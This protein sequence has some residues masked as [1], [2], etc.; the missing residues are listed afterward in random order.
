MSWNKLSEE[1]RKVVRARATRR[2]MSYDAPSAD[3]DLVVEGRGI[4]LTAANRQ[5]RATV[6]KPKTFDELIAAAGPGDEERKAIATTRSRI[7]QRDQLLR[8][9]LAREPK[10]REG[11]ARARLANLA[12]KAA[13]QGVLSADDLATLRL[14]SVIEKLIPRIDIWQWLFPTIVVKAGS[15]LTFSGSPTTVHSL[16]AHKLLIEPNARVV[17]NKVPVAI[18]CTHLEVQ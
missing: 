3:D 12:L 9:A 11:A 7:N 16:V 10:E 14:S 6:V 5:F 1:E 15:T 4:T 17:I 18:D 2:G 13:L 8:H